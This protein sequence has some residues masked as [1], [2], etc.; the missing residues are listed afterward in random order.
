MLVFIC[1]IT[2]LSYLLLNY[3]GKSQ[4]QEIPSTTPSDNSE[5]NSTGT[6][7]NSGSNSSPPENTDILVV[8]EVPLGILGSISALAIAFGIFI[9]I[10]KK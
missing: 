1:L 8:P 7:N 5:S 4:S 6:N 2:A 9:I 3:N 10:K